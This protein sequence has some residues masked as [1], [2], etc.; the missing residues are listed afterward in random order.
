MAGY[1]RDMEKRPNGG[2]GGTNGGQPKP[3]AAPPANTPVFKRDLYADLQKIEDEKRLLDEGKL[4]LKLGAV[5]YWFYFLV[6][7]G[8]HMTG[9]I[10]SREAKYGERMI[11]VRIRFWTDEITEG[12]GL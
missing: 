9:S 7:G 5:V 11:E 8:V 3:G 4:G 12:E 6:K 2:N 10:E 1:Q